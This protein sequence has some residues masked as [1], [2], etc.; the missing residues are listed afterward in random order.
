[1]LNLKT[2][3]ESISINFKSA[4]Q[5]VEVKLADLPTA[6]I[7]YLLQGA[8]RKFNDAVNSK[9]REIREAGGVVNYQQLINEQLERINTGNFSEARQA[10]GDSAFRQFVINQLKTVYKIPAKTFDNLKGATPKVILQSV[11]VDKSEEQIDSA[12]SQLKTLWE[13]TQITLDLF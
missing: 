11:F 5:I 1:M 12:V 4:E 2:S 10:S 8:T 6:T 7:D 3:L 9:A 13:S